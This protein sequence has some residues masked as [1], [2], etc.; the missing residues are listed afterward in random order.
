MQPEPSSFKC[1]SAD[2]EK[3]ALKR[4]RSLVTF[5][6]PDCRVFRE[7]WDCSTVLCLDFAN[8]PTFLDFTRQNAHLLIQSAQ[9]LGLTNAVIFRLGNKFMGWKSMAPPR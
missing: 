4:F 2:F 5:L 8:C 1:T 6:P 3:A 9:E 7:T